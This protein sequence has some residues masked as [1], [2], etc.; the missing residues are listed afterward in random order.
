MLKLVFACSIF[1]ILT[2][3][4]TRIT[5]Q[6]IPFENPWRPHRVSAALLAK[7]H[8]A[9]Q[10]C[11]GGEALPQSVISDLSAKRP[12][13]RLDLGSFSAVS[14]CCATHSTL[15]CTGS[16]CRTQMAVRAWTV[17]VC[18][19]VE[20]LPGAGIGDICETHAVYAVGPRLVHS[21]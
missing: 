12:C 9:A 20:M 10:M 8:P 19:G 16:L 2:C 15:R 13:M 18:C 17:L 1:E 5:V 7:T 3:E 6:L 14:H 21:F 11:C 4:F